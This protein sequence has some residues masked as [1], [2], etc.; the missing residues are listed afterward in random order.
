MIEYDI[1]MVSKKLTEKG[2]YY[3][4]WRKKAHNSS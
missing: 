4:E 3:N 2:V 1:K